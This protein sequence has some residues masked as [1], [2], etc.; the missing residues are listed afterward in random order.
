MSAMIKKRRDL[1]LIGYKLQ[2]TKCNN[3][4]YRVKSE[5]KIKKGGL[6]EQNVHLQLEKK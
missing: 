6:T 2:Q 1:S 4:A 3:V 5:R